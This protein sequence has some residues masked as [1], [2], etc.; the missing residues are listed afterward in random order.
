MNSEHV[1]KVDENLYDP[2]FILGVSVTDTEEHINK[3]FK[4][5]AK[6]WHPDKNQHK[7]KNDLK[8]IKEMYNIIVES[9]NYIINQKTHF[10][11]NNKKNREE[12]NIPK[13]QN[14]PIKSLDNSSELNNFNAE[15]EKLKVTTPN[16]FG[17]Q[18]ERIQ[19]LSEYE[20][21]EHKPY[22][23]FDNKNFNPNEFNKMFEYN[24]E[25]YQKNDSQEL[26]LYYKT[27]D[28]FT[29][30]NSGDVGNAAN[31]SSYNGV[32]IVGDMYGQTG[33]GYYD[34]MYSD[35]KQTFDGAKNP[36]NMINIPDT[37]QSSIK[38]DDKLNETQSRK[39]IELQ[40]KARQ[41]IISPSSNSRSFKEEEQILLRKQDEQILQKIE[42]DKKLI[43]QYSN[44]Y[45][46]DTIEA[47]FNGQLIT[48]S[49]YVNENNLS[50]RRLLSKKF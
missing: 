47:A 18:V 25:K 24:Q 23:L 15:F 41:N 7:S 22:Q 8:N 40:L 35:Y 12:I 17:Y 49:D 42:K 20:N 39:Q 21:F 6:K 38:I 14:L 9:Y 1:I 43:L 2:Y 46:K 11:I 28:G 10:I 30:Y 16:D 27:T 26:G 45:D 4:I 37:Y 31:V 44:M 3:A 34:A 36:N 29:A 48:N 13:T 32:M 50:N 5:L 19:N 33:V